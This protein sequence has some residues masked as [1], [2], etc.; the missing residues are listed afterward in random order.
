MGERIGKGGGGDEVGAMWCF[1]VRGFKSYF[2]KD[3]WNQINFICL[4]LD[5]CSPF[6]LYSMPITPPVDAYSKTVERWH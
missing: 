2:G 4:D 3:E 1:N 6:T 5:R